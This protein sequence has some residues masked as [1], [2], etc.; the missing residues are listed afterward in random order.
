[1]GISGSISRGWQCVGRC[2]GLS[3]NLAVSFS[4]GYLSFKSVIPLS[5]SSSSP[6]RILTLFA[7]S[8]PNRVVSQL[9]SLT[10][11]SDYKRGDGIAHGWRDR[12]YRIEIM[13][14]AVIVN[15]RATVVSSIHVRQ[16]CHFQV[17][18]ENDK[19]LAIWGTKIARK[20]STSM[21]I[22]QWRIGMRCYGFPISK[23]C[24][25]LMNR[26]CYLRI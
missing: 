8:P 4:L 12:I 14:Y 21:L 17:E 24:T 6:F 10:S 25:E 9:C 18:I 1:M 3:T 26:L 20:L 2:Q 13:C 5:C 7:A 22:E 15:R 19:F 16:E 11:I 23:S